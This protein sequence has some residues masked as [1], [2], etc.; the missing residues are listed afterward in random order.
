MT[1]NG[2]IRFALRDATVGVLLR[3]LFH[4]AEVRMLAQDGSQLQTAVL[5][6]GVFVDIP[7]TA[8]DDHSH[9]IILHVASGQ[10]CF[11][12]LTM[13]AAA[14]PRYANDQPTIA[15]LPA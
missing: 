3:S 14:A 15:H 12:G 9:E 10:V 4:G 8:E 5:P 7:F 11:F 6:P 1:G 2:I 13:N